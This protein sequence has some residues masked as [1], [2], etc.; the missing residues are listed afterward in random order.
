VVRPEAEG[1]ELA[2][3]F[4][5]VAVSNVLQVGTER[6]VEHDQGDVEQAIQMVQDHEL[7]HKVLQS[8]H[9]HLNTSYSGKVTAKVEKFTLDKFLPTSEEA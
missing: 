4:Y 5:R 6:I 8:P 7:V 3:Y 1:E 2:D 9:R